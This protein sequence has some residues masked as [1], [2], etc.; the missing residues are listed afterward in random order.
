MDIEEEIKL[1]VEMKQLCKLYIDG[2]T[3]LSIPHK[4]ESNNPVVIHANKMLV[5]IKERLSHFCSHVIED[6]FIEIGEIIKRVR[7]CKICD[8]NFS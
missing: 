4:S 3:N 7:Y 2:K 6:D 8:T 1:L 5:S